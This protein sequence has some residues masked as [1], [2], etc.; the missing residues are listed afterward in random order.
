MIKNSLWKRMVFGYII[1]ALFMLAMS[2]YLIFRLNHLNKVTDSIMKTDIPSIKN[3]EKL[4]D[5]LLEQ[6]RNEKKYVI[7]N[8]NAFLDLFDKKKRE[9]LERLKSIEESIPNRE[10]KV[11]IYPIRDLH[12]K[13]LTMVSKEIVLIGS[14]EHVPPDSRYEEEIKKTLDQLT[15]SINKLT[16]ALQTGLIKKIE[17][18]QKIGY[19]SAKVSLIIILFAVL[20]GAI[21]AYFFTRSVCSP[22]KILKDAT[23][24]I[25]DGDLDY[26]IEVTARDE[27]GTLGTAFN[28]MCNKLK[29]MDQ[30]KSEFVSNIS[31]NLKTPLTAI[32][33]AN[34]L[35]LEKIA[36]PISEQ[37]IKLLNITKKEA[38][39]LTMMIN[40]LLDISRVEAGLMRYNF[41]SADIHDVIR[42]STD[43]IRFLTEN[44]NIHIQCEN[45]DS[46]P[47]ILLDRDKIVQVMDNLL[48]NAIK[49]TLPGG[50]ITIKATVVESHDVTQFFREQNSM[51][52]VHSFIKV[53]ISD[54][55]IGIPSECHKK[56]FDKFQQ[57]NNKGKGGIKGTGLGLSIAR[58]IVLDHGGDIWV[59]SNV[60]KGSTFLFTLPCSYDYALSI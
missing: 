52:N 50:F 55:G 4:I 57:V 17:L 43:E 56:I 3:G 40:D 5:S 13:Y 37:Q 51:N 14:E 23:D 39:Q 21:F 9:F 53:S 35:L 12:N 34:D 38:H 41:Q 18:F 24:R 59:E 15:E 49:F 22:I 32:R 1:I 26:R 36:G 42:K 19:K 58:H 44:K 16:L 7:T 47:K 48:S 46:I 20:F 54:T 31:H 11:L 25:A 10:K 29:E 28:Q 60:G 6:V 2:F 45:G 33:E 8:D 30:M 27:I